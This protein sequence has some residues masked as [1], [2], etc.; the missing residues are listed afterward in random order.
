MSLERSPSL[1]A[2]IDAAITMRL[3]GARFALPG[4]IES[5]DAGTQQ[6]TVKPLLKDR[7]LRP[8]GT[9]NVESLP[10]IPGVPVQFPSS[11]GFMLTIP[12]AKGDP[13]L[14]LF[15]DRSL[16]LWIQRGGEVYPGDVRI[17]DLNDAV[18]ILGVRAQPDALQEFDDS[19]QVMGKIS[20]P[21]IAISGSAIHLGVDH[22]ENASDA[23]AL[24]SKVMDDLNKL[25]DAHNDLVNTFNAHTHTV[26]T[27]GSPVAHSGTTVPPSSSGSQVG[28]MG[29]VKSTIVKAK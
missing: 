22:N 1:A 12:V 4:S 25:K 13:C 10:V 23:I 18:V 5:F 28:S 11:G 9:Y 29:E 20:G 27:V 17:H 8:D 2:V 24:A 26:N 21:R 7:A 16:D 19:R 6:C 14:I 3:T 15:A